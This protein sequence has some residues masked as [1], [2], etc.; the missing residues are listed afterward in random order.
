MKLLLASKI[1]IKKAAEKRKRP[2][3]KE[4]MKIWD[5]AQV[6][7]SCFSNYSPVLQD[8]MFEG[9]FYQRRKAAH[10]KT[11]WLELLFNSDIQ[12]TCLFDFL[13]FVAK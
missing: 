7:A 8:R 3:T 1:E 6:F 9:S 10:I 2:Q 5:K 4:A 11:L 12:S 13:N